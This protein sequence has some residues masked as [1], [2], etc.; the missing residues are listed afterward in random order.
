MFGA[1]PDCSTP[2]SPPAA[3]GRGRSCDAT[4]AKLFTTLSRTRETGRTRIVPEVVRSFNVSERRPDIHVRAE[5]DVPL[6]Q[7]RAGDR[8]ELRR[9]V[10]PQRQ[11]EAELPGETPGLAAGGR[12]SQRRHAGKAR[13]IS[14]VQVL[15]RY[16][17]R[18]RLTRR[19]GDFVARLT[20]PSFCPILPGTPISPAGMDNPPGSGPYYIADRVPDRRIV[21]ERNP[22]YG[23]SRTANPDRIVWTIEPDA[24][25]E[26]G[27]PSGTRTT[28]RGCSPPRTM[29]SATSTSRYG[30]N[31]PGGRFL[32]LPSLIE[33]P[34]RVQP[35]S[36]RVQGRRPGAAQ[37]GDQLRARQ[38]GPDQAH[39]YLAA[40]RSDRLLPAPLSASRRVYPLG[41]PDLATA[42]KWLARAEAAAAEAHPLHG[43]LRLHASR[44]PRCSARTC[45]SSASRST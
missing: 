14:G 5:A 37:E 44:A 32:R 3:S 9:R 15:G 45:G 18:V 23:G 28:S 7:P 17:L 21:L 36:A 40:R 41:G 4:C 35:R 34:L 26:S 29:S 6:P 12:R 33:L 20:M 25:S 2:P 10:Q 13:T 11:P 30:L 42:R 19:A 22:Y 38:A 43:E 1:E 24:P 8:A 31:R 16:R 27:R 39:G